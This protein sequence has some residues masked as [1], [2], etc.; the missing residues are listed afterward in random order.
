GCCSKLHFCVRPAMIAVN[1]DCLV[2][3]GCALLDGFSHIVVMAVVI[4]NKNGVREQ[5]ECC[6]DILLHMLVVVTCVN[7][8]NLRLHSLL[9]Q[10][11]QPRDCVRTQ[12]RQPV[13]EPPQVH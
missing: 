1:M 10:V 8:N 4:S 5:V 3:L 11:V 12:R 7:V 2:V 6:G 9:V 13:S